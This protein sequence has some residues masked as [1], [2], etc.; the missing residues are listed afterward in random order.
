[1]F[2]RN[3]ECVVFVFCVLHAFMNYMCYLKDKSRLYFVLYV[4]NENVCYLRVITKK[5]ALVTPKICVYS[6]VRCNL[7]EPTVR[8]RYQIYLQYQISLHSSW[9][10]FLILTLYVMIIQNKL[11]YIFVLTTE[12]NCIIIQVLTP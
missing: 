3:V 5:F 12:G 11:V 1:M 9:I 6:F 2:V 7:F 10:S 8:S 4:F